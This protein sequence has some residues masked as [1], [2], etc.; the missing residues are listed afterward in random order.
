LAEEAIALARWFIASGGMRDGRGRMS[1]HQSPL[2]PGFD[3]AIPPCAPFRPTPGPTPS[4]PMV[5]LP[6]GQ[7]GADLLDHMAD[8]PLRL[9][10]WRM[11]LVESAA[12]MPRHPGLITD[13]Q[14]SLLRVVA[15]P[16]APACPQAMAPV[17]DL[18][19]DLAPRVPEGQL[20][21]VSGCA[22]LCAHPR[23]ADITL[24]AEKDG[25]ALFHAGLPGHR[26]LPDAQALLTNDLWIKALP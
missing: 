5:A 2:P 24:V 15:C 25:F 17:R 26:T 10:P 13:R 18:A 14:D 3:I 12:A 21:H 7:I 9:T 20:L 4:G 16:G 23:P 1:A 11:I 8:H 22:K 19:R 6:F